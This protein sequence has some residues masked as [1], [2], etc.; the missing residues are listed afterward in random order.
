[1]CL[2]C[3]ADLPPCSPTFPLK[4]T[5]RVHTDTQELPERHGR[6]T[7]GRQPAFA[8][9]PSNCRQGRDSRTEADNSNAPTC[10]VGANLSVD[11]GDPR[12]PGAVSVNDL[13][14]ANGIDTVI[15]VHLRDVSLTDKGQRH[16]LIRFPEIKI[17][18]FDRNGSHSPLAGIVRLLNYFL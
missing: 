7:G 6:K 12:R 11:R 18:W 4:Y 10:A 16:G 14:A 17:S 15:D 2:Y 8:A 13:H 5:N 9:A 3:N 1:M